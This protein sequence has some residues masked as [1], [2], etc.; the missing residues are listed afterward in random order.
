M[1]KKFPAVTA[2]RIV[3]TVRTLSTSPVPD[4]EVEVTGVEIKPHV[5]GPATFVNTK[6]IIA[7]AKLN[8]KARKKGFGPK[9]AGDGPVTPGEDAAPTLDVKPG[10]NKVGL[11]L[12]DVSL[13][14]LVVRVM[15]KDNT[16]PVPSA[17]VEVVGQRGPDPV[18]ATGKVIYSNLPVGTVLNIKARALGFGR[19]NNLTNKPIIGT[20]VVDTRSLPAGVTTVTLILETEGAVTKIDGTAPGTVSLRTAANKLPD[21]AFSSNNAAEPLASNAPTVLVRGCNKVKLKATTNPAGLN[22]DWEVKPIG[23]T[24]AA[25]AANPQFGAKET[26]VSTDK[27]GAFSVI[28]HLGTTKIVWNVVFVHVKVLP[29]TT[30]V[31]HRKT[32]FVDSGSS[33]NFTQFRSGVFVKGSGAMEA[34]VTVDLAAGGSR[35]A[36]LGK[37][38]LHYLQN[39]TADTLGG[40]FRG[41]GHVAEVPATGM[42]IL[43]NNGP[44]FPAGNPNVPAIPPRTAAPPQAISSPF[45]VAASSFTDTKISAKRHKIFA[46]DSPAGGFSNRHTTKNDPLSPGSP[47]PPPVPPQRAPLIAITGV[48][49]FVVT[50][51]S[52]STDAPGA[53]VIH[54]KL[55]WTADFSG[56]VNYPHPP[57]HHPATEIPNNT[58]GSYVRTTAQ[59]TG[60]PKY[61]LVGAATGGQ[62][63]KDAGVEVFEPRFN[64]AIGSNFT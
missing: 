26:V 18:D 8:L 29:D 31:I 52:T 46:L 48:N 33:G 11:T 22:V 20:E 54:A 13:A 28:A 40:N 42:P 41:G 50:I 14:H 35:D 59:V 57:A 19:L 44:N 23:H 15:R 37:I 63:A 62:D 5:N 3:A 53:I 43:D 32:G 10:T 24:G 38:Q 1:A 49:A 4:S 17:R 25:P 45:V 7:G 51:A 16:T 56:N 12:L 61:V 36:D 30:V 47:G 55:K 39:G 58:I 34:T 6:K 9:P 21:T 60:D 2:A 27:P 64:G